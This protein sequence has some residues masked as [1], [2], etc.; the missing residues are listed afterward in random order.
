MWGCG[1]QWSS[2]DLSVM[3][4]LH[5]GCRGVRGHRWAGNLCGPGQFELCRLYA[6]LGHG[7]GHGIRTLSIGSSSDA[8]SVVLTDFQAS[9][10]RSAVAA[11]PR[12]SLT[13]MESI[14]MEIS[15]VFTIAV[16]RSQGGVP[17]TF[18]LAKAE[19]CPAPGVLYV[20][21]TEGPKS[22]PVRYCAL[23]S[24][25]SSLFPKGAAA[26]TRSALKF[27]TTSP[28]P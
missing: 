15:A 11:L 24:L 6:T 23:R 9:A 17:S 18:W 8:T 1:S 7:C 12:L 20:H 2:N 10:L 5:F 16:V 4:I 26:G 28:N 21:T 19:L 13:P 3:E 25:V 22:F 27:C 14:C